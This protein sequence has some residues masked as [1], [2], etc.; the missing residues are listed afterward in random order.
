LVVIHK[1]TPKTKDTIFIPV[2]KSLVYSTK[3][4]GKMFPATENYSDFFDAGIDI[5][6]DMHRSC[7][8]NSL[9]LHP[10]HIYKSG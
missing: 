6:E 10:V 4:S 1:R 7:P 2:L 8:D 5:V 9:H 3:V